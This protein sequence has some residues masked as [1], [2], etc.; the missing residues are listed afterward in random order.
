MNSFRLFRFIGVIVYSARWN[1]FW[2]FNKT[3]ALILSYVYSCINPF[4]LYFL[5]S[6][7]RHFYN[8]YIFFWKSDSCFCLPKSLDHSIHGPRFGDTMTFSEGI[9]RSS[10]NNIS[11]TATE[12][13]RYRISSHLTL[14]TRTSNNILA[15]RISAENE[16]RTNGQIYH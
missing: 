3:V 2:Q 16:V 5:S 10:A 7:F 13:N 12:L 11:M 15:N 6:T 8:R 14:Q 9:R 4:A 1:H